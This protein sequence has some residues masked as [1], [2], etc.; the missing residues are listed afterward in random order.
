MTQSERSHGVS[1][2]SADEEAG[3]SGAGERERPWTLLSL[4]PQ[5]LDLLE[6]I[7]DGV[8]VEIL[9]ADDLGRLS[10]E[11]S[12]SVELILAD[13]RPDRPGM[14]TKSVAALPRLAFVQQPSVGV[15][16]HDAEALAA[17]GIPLSNVAGFNAAAVTEWVVGAAL[18][19]SRMMRWA[20]DELRAGRWPQTEIA[21][22]GSAEIAGRQVGIVGFGPIGQGC[23]RAFA[24]LGCPVAYWSRHARPSEQEFGAR[25]Q[26]DLRELV[27]TSGV[28][29]NAIALGP[30]TRGLLG[31]DELGLLPHGA[32]LISAS[33]GGIVDESAVIDLLSAGS[34]GG[35]AFDVY[36]EE[37]LSPGNPLLSAPRDRLL[38]SP[39]VAGSTV[40][41]N[42]RL[43][44][45]V[46]ANIGRAVA[47]TPVIDV[48][49]GVSPKVRR[50]VID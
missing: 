1:D 44:N 16:S 20:E 32:L 4:A 15:Q 23:A 28:L 24:G 47:G 17:A 2:F 9:Q 14:T 33:R 18:S 46:V 31:R 38:L 30:E 50:R 8:P 25:Y 3:E 37:P 26:P 45:A 39:H 42:V 19:V 41:S 40:Q 43:I 21:Q 13:W 12:S 5:P 29:V 48:V 11:Q 7:F 6:M 27:A 22:R 49:N 35:A 10:T 34:L 36:D